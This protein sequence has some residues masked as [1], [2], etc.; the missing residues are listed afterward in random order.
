M[1][2]EKD[3]DVYL[4][5]ISGYASAIDTMFQSKRT[6][7]RK[8]EE[9]LYNLEAYVL[10]DGGAIAFVEEDHDINDEAYQEFMGYLRKLIKLGQK[11]I[12]LLRFIDLEFTVD[13]IHR[14]A[15]DDF[16]AHAKRLDNR[17]VRAS[18]RLSTFGTEKSDWYKDKILTLDE[19]LLQCGIQMPEKITDESGA[20]WVKTV[21]GYVREDLTDVK[22]VMRGL[23][24]LSIPST[25]T[26]KCNLTEFAHIVKLR[27]KN[28]NAAPELQEMIESLLAQIEEKCSLFTRD[29][30]YGIEN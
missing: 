21:N 12:T 17:I 25:F 22:D 3:M 18:T 27:D 2:G 30:F 20:V 1:I 16:D 23:Y 26:A 6:W 9:R 8:L 29:F 19:V 28:S 14:G 13:G 4:N 10:G 24:M 7:T 11:H 5:K 15:Q